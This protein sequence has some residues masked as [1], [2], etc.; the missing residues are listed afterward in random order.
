MDSSGHYWDANSCGFTPSTKLTAGF[1]GFTWKLMAFQKDLFRSQNP[2]TK[3]QHTST[4]TK[5]DAI[6]HGE[7]HSNSSQSESNL[8]CY[9]MWRPSNTESPLAY[10]QQRLL[11][12]RVTKPSKPRVTHSVRA[13]AAD[14]LARHGGGIVRLHPRG[15]VKWI[16]MLKQKGVVV[17]PPLKRKRTLE[18][19]PPETK[20]P[21][22]IMPHAYEPP[23]GFHISHFGALQDYW[24]E[25]WIGWS[26][27]LSHASQ[28]WVSEVLQA[29]SRWFEEECIAPWLSCFFRSEDS[30]NRQ[31][32]QN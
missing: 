19:T 12:A 16:S 11:F 8:F 22:R 23:N 26:G 18:P 31:I 25:C 17:Q 5:H 9:W 2:I 21:L 20:P 15:L 13:I 29:C 32:Q 7:H 27:G 6:F 14:L 24:C 1:T 3:R 30:F 28:H 10:K 4:Y